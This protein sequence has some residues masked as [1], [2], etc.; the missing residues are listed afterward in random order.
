[1]W[2]GRVFLTTVVSQGE[3]EPPKKGL[4]F[5]GERPEPPKAEHR[6]KVLALDLATGAVQWE[7][8][9][10]QGPPQTSI[11]L[12]SSYGAETPVTDG[13]RVYALFGNLGVYALTL[14]GTEV[15]SKRLE[16]RKTRYGWGAAASPVAQGGRLYLVN[17]NEDQSELLALDTKTGEVVWRA[18]RDEKSNWATPFMWESGPRTELITPGSRAVRSYGVDGK[19]L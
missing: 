11:H 9:V 10:H 12:K 2:G 1:V 8:G 14:E 17:D 6:W 19:L 7:K 18:E 4:Y 5:G 3:S 16:P 13:E 15:W